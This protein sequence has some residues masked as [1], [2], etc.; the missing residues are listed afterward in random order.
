MDWTTILMVIVVVA[1]LYFLMIRPQRKRAKEQKEHMAS[2]Q[3]GSRVMT[4]HGIFGTI[5]HMGERQAIIEI[6]PG[7][8]LTILK[9]AISNQPV[10]D[11]FEY[12][13]GTDEDTA[14]VPSGDWDDA[15]AALTAADTASD[16]TVASDD[17]DAADLDLTVE[18]DTADDLDVPAADDAA[19]AD[20]PAEKAA[21]GPASSS[22]IPDF[23]D[24]ESFST[25][26]DGHFPADGDAPKGD[27]S[28]KGD[29]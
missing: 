24:D 11:E 9:Q 4:V 8:E 3:P 14:I 28:P 13:D 15:A 5:V 19:V 27:G 22:S 6:S 12:D 25:W 23:T 16:T 26:W 29:A 21:D 18:D 2:L 17:D 1:A 7:V 10:Q 20:K